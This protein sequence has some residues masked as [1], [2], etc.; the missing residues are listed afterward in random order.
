MDEMMNNPQN[1]ENYP[2]PEEHPQEIP[3]VQKTR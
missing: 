3:A 2:A 1:P